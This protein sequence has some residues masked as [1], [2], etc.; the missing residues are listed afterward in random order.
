[1]ELKSI[2][3]SA[4]DKAKIEQQK[5][6]VRVVLE[7][8]NEIPGLPGI[9]SQVLFQ[10]LKDA[11]SG[12]PAENKD[13]LIKKLVEQLEQANRKQGNDVTQ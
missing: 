6:T 5:N 13:E 11:D 7:K 12:Q 4:E 10:F 2:F 3:E 1:M 9:I 8:T